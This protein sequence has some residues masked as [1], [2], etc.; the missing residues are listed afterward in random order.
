MPAPR[1]VLADI[2]EFGLNPKVAHYTVAKDGRLKIKQPTLQVDVDKPIA[3][4]TV[5]TQQVQE[6]TLIVE[7]PVIQSEEISNAIF[8]VEEQIT[9]NEV[10]S[11]RK[12]KKNTN[13]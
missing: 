3:Q 4:P 7:E 8:T 9:E 1:A 5:E 13:S 6:K 12:K 11:T 2:H 10:F